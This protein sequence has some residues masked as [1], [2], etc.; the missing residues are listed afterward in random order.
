MTTLKQRADWFA[1]AF[2]ACT[3][4]HHRELEP[5]LRPFVPNDAVVLDIGAHAGQFSKLFAAMAPA[6][7]VHAFEPSPYARSILTRALAWNRIANVEVTPL[8]LSDAA[9]EQTLY[10]P[11]KK[12]GGMGFGIAHLGADDSGRALVEHRIQL[13]TID[14]YCQGFTRLDLIKID[15]EGWEV[16][17][18]TGGRATIA[19]FHPAILAEVDEHHLARAGH[20][21]QDV[22]DLLTPLGYTARDIATGQPAPAYGGVGDYLWVAAGH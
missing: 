3:Q 1:H 15:V 9:G 21:P 6:G 7:R 11:I 22:W 12:R 4:Q 13:T 16:S 8:G 10:T 19:R 18:L 17:A 5:V 20:T 2:K 14:A